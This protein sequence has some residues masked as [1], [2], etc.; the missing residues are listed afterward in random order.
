VDPVIE[1]WVTLAEVA[2]HLQVAEETIHRW[3]RGK[4]MTAHRAGRNWRFKLSQVDAWMQS[5][6][7]APEGSSDD[8]SSTGKP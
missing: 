4:G 8:D 1:P 5:G 6:D 2:A 7:A 3:I